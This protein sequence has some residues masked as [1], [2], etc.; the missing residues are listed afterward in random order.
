MGAGGTSLP[1]FLQ[2]RVIMGR[3]LENEYSRIVLEQGLP[4]L[5]LWLCF[6]LWFFFQKV[7]EK[8]EY[9]LSRTMMWAFVVT[10]FGTAWIGIGTFTTVPVTALLF[11]SMGYCVKNDVNLFMKKLESGI[12]GESLNTFALPAYQRGLAR[13]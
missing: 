12:S 2:N 9:R 4:G 8:S 1:Y 13:A 6:L 5:F 3:S 10:V 11:L 7:S